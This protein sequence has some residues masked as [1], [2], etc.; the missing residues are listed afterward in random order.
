MDFALR[1]MLCVLTMLPA[2]AAATDFFDPTRPPPAFMP[3]TGSAPAAEAV[4]PDLVL[5]AVQR[6]PQRASALINGHRVD[7]GQ[8]I[9]AYQLVRLGA[10]QAE[11]AS[12]AGTRILRLS[13]E[14]KRERTRSD[15]GTRGVQ[16]EKKK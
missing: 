14:V 3:H 11:L 6:T 9:G 7:V 2:F 1:R 12:P 15:A 4:E 16:G 13:I 8:R 5:Q 10:D